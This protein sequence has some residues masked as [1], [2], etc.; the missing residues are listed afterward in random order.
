MSIEFRA[1]ARHNMAF[2]QVERVGVF[3][4]REGDVVTQTPKLLLGA[5]EE[6]VLEVLVM[7]AVL[8]EGHGHDEHGIDA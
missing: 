2:D 8:L 5:V 7:G 4:E 6:D 1:I 3:R